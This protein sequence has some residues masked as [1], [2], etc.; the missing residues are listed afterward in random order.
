MCCFLAILPS[1]Y[2]GR[3]VPLQTNR[4]QGFMC[5]A[6]AGVPSLLHIGTSIGSAVIIATFIRAFTWMTTSSHLRGFHYLRLLFPVFLCKRC[7]YI[8]FINAFNFQV[9][10]YVLQEDYPQRPSGKAVVSA[11]PRTCVLYRS[12]GSAFPLFS[13]FFSSFFVKFCQLALHA[14]PV[15]YA[16]SSA[17]ELE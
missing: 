14:S 1:G 16:K 7:G 13:F 8:L 5:F 11:P 15:F 12:K 3:C 9:K 4:H 6:S 17:D 2:I 10:S